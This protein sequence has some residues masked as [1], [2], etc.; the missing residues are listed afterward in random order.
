MSTANLKKRSALKSQQAWYLA[1]NHLNLLY[2][3]AAGLVMEP[4]WFRGKHYVDSLGAVPGWVPLFRAAIPTKAVN[5][6]VGE[7]K[8][9]RPCIVSFDLSGVSGPVQ[10]LS[11][12]GKARNAK[13]PNIRLG[14]G[15]VG[16][17]VRAPLPLTLISRIS[18]QSDEDQLIFEAAA[19]DVSNIDLTS[20]RI[21]IV[22]E[23]SLFRDA[24]DSAWPPLQT[25]MG[26][27]RDVVSQLEQPYFSVQALGGLLSMLYHCANRSELGV[28]VFQLVTGSLENTS[29]SLIIDP[30]LA[31]LPKWLNGEEMS[32]HSKIPTKLYWGTI[33]ALVAAQEGSHSTQPVEVTLE[34]LV[35]QAAQL[36]DD[37]YK[38]RLD[39]LIEDIRSLLGLGGGTITELFERHKGSLSRPLLLFCLREHCSD[40]LEFSHPLLNDA[41]Y[42]L[43]GILLGVRA[44]WLKLPCE[45]RNEA[46]SD[47]S[48]YRMACFAHQKQGSKLILP[49]ARSPQPLRAL[50]TSDAEPWRKSQIN[51][52]IEIAKANK[53]SDCIDTVITS[54]DGFPLSEPKQENGS[55]IFSG[56]TTS[57]TTIR[58]DVFLKHLGEWQPID[59][60]MESTIRKYFNS[61]G[62]EETGQT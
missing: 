26:R 22:V 9:L 44:G 15:G 39:R 32:E 40:M 55:F 57:T 4:S 33:N 53:W 17:L 56:G 24:T 49:E 38:S 8:H 45:L 6:A 18:F 52:A 28:K 3:L 5:E 48:M 60:K 25:A 13:L 11:R 50:F 2:M 47:Y 1:T 16:I 36:T 46:L 19:K 37:K 23:E 59:A 27:Q 31:E 61:S 10:V 62:K 43:A 14:K 12:E 7:R 42:L 54:T 51:A 20:Y 30:I 35:A 34:Y 21:P 29:S 41:D 58:H